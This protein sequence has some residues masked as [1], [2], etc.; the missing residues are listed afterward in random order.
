MKERESIEPDDVMGH[1]EV[2][3]RPVCAA[4]R[5]ES[6][7]NHILC[8]L[9]QR[10]QTDL[11]EIQ[12]AFYASPFVSVL[13]MTIITQRRSEKDERPSLMNSISGEMSCYRR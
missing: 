4:L 11:H 13:G 5:Y 2:F 10:S 12:P 7:L 1:I 3:I 6:F 8:Q 9:F